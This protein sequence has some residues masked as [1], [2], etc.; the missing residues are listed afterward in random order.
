MIGYKYSIEQEAIDARKLAA[1]FKG[2]PVEG[3]GS[4]YWVD[5]N[6][7]INDDF[8]YIVYVDGLDN[9]LGS[10]IEFIVAQNNLPTIGFQ[11]YA[12]IVTEEIKSTYPNLPYELDVNGL[13]VLQWSIVYDD[14]YNYAL[15]DLLTLSKIKYKPIL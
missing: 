8:Y 7:S 3:G 6:Y 15:S 9:A 2:L 13:E 5:Y 14:T 4:L 12:L 10:P 11:G 1:D